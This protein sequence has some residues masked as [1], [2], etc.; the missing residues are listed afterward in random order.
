MTVL[1]IGLTRD[2]W[3]QDL[4]NH[5]VDVD[6]NKFLNEYRERLLEKNIS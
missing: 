3:F 4:N 2:G 5:Y 6:F 1:S